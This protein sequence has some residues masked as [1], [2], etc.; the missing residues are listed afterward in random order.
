MKWDST[1]NLIVILLF[2]F[3]PLP[4]RAESLIFQRA[5][6]SDTFQA[7]GRIIALYGVEPPAPSDPNA[8]AATLYL[9]TLL[10]H[11]PLDCRTVPATPRMACQA[12]G[13]DVASQLVQMG[14]G[15]SAGPVYA[16]EQAEAQRHRRGIWRDQGIQ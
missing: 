8:Y 14:M 5:I 2:V 12:N 11:G 7:S 10:A 16:A 9:D 3:L 15:R 13:A 6:A 1:L 4:A